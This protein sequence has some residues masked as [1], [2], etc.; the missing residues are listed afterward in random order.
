MNKIKDLKDMHC[1]CD[2]FVVIQ[3]Y[4]NIDKYH[5]K[6]KIEKLTGGF[7]EVKPGNQACKN[8]FKRSF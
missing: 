5:C 2:H 3:Q 8:E 1:E 7:K 6:I 4:N